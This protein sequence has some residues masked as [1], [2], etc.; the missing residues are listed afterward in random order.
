MKVIFWLNKFQKIPTLRALK[1]SP[2]M[3][4]PFPLKRSA[5]LALSFL[6]I[7]Q[8]CKQAASKELP[9]DAI[10]TMENE[11]NAVT[12][13]LNTFGSNYAAAWSGQEPAAV[14]SFFA[15]DGS[16][17]VNDNEPA[18]GTVAITDVARG[19]MEAFPD[20]LVVMDSL[21]ESPRGLQFYWTLTGTYAGP[22]GAGNKVHISGVEIWQLNAQGLVQTS[23][24][25]FDEETYN[26]QLKGDLSDKQGP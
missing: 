1:K 12:A 19:F 20:M 13:A 21:V 26:R 16:L 11:K 6:L 2:E 10:S 4:L 17:K 18:M 24:G 22:E 25:L 8:A 5:F 3:I 15:S 23:I 7:S 14:A 9:V